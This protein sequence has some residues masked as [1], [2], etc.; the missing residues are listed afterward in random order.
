[1]LFAPSG[2]DVRCSAAFCVA[3]RPVLGPLQSVMQD[4]HSD[5]N[6]DDSEDDDDDVDSDAERPAHMHP[7]HHQRRSV[8]AGRGSDGDSMIDVNTDVSF[9]SKC[10]QNS[11]SLER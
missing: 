10:K 4:L 6:E 7:A 9:S 8:A 2:S 11:C 3:S 1:M 5:D